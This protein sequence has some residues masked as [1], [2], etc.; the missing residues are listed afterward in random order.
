[1]F[2]ARHQPLLSLSAFARRMLKAV[3]LAVGLDAIVLTAG[4]I[5]LRHT[6]GVGWTDAFLNAALVA[7]G[8]GPVLRAQSVAGKIFL[9]GYALAGVIVFAA[10]ISVVI[11]PILHRTLHAFHADVPEDTRPGPEAR[12]P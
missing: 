12:Q 11:A 2:E 6:E 7:T 3:A 9:L 4:A 1:M 8:N 5:G 10:V